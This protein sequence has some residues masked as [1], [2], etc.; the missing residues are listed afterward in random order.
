[1]FKYD[2]QIIKHNFNIELKL[3][4]DTMILAW[5][6]NTQEKVGLDFLASKYFDHKMIAIKDIVKK[7]ETFAHVDMQKATEYASE[8]AF[9][10]F[11][12]YEKLLE[13]FRR[14]KCEHLIEVAKNVEFDFIYVL[15]YME[16]N[17][18]K[19]DV[20]LLEKLKA[21]NSQYLQELTQQIYGFTANKF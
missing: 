21:T 1:N 18:I 5:L 7:D 8:D 15:A 9:M 4:A 14:L 17:G 16:D 11:K 12:L 13:E 20:A 3:Y 6:L 19:V 10:T 2:Y